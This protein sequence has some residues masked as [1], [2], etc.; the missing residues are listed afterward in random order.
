VTCFEDDDEDMND[1]QM[2]C[3]RYRDSGDIETTTVE[4][5]DEQQRAHNVWLQ[6]PLGAVVAKS[7]KK[8]KAKSSGKVAINNSSS[9]RRAVSAQQSSS[10]ASTSEKGTDVQQ[11]DVTRH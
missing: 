9:S 7:A 11:R 4:E 1:E 10:S 5:L 6:A 8:A 2:R 3:I